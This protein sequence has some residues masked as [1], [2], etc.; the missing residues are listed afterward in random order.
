MGGSRSHSFCHRNK[1]ETKQRE[2]TRQDTK[3]HEPTEPTPHEPKPTNRNEPKRSLQ[4]SIL[5]V[6]TS[7]EI[8][9]ESLRQ[10]EKEPFKSLG[11]KCLVFG[12]GDDDLEVTINS[13]IYSRHTLYLAW[14]L[15]SVW[16]TA[17]HTGNLFLDISCLHAVPDAEVDDVL[18]LSAT[19]TTIVQ[20]LRH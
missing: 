15:S 12:N 11:T 8:A 18:R 4:D 10:R 7:G 5:D 17:Q 2:S 6:V 13:T 9:W 14:H 16:A 1:T 3:Q 20:Q 19:N